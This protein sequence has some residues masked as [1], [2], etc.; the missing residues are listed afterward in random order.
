MKELRGPY[1][2]KGNKPA[3]T[4]RGL[5]ILL[6]LP[7]VLA[8]FALVLQVGDHAEPLA[9]A[10]TNTVYERSIPHLILAHPPAL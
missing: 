10:P 2:S 3:Q 4:S 8:L 6:G 9:L 5:Q 7:L 1:N